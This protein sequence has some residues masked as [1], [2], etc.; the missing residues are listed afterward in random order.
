M[1]AFA[2]RGA[3]SDESVQQGLAQQASECVQQLSAACLLPGDPGRELPAALR[4]IGIDIDGSTPSIKAPWP[5]ACEISRACQYTMQA[6]MSV[7]Q[8]QVFICSHSSRALI[9]PRRP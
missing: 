9:R 2:G 6:R 5:M 4:E 3:G 1:V 7:R 8:L